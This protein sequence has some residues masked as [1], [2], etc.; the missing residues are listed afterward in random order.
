MYSLYVH[1]AT[2]VPLMYHH[3]YSVRIQEHVITVM[4]YT[5]R[6]QTQLFNTEVP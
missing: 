3:P 1:L 5:Q 4:Q 6:I 2:T